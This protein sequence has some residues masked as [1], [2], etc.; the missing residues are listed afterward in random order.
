VADSTPEMEYRETLNKMEGIKK[1]VKL[2]E[3]GLKL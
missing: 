2:A 1:A 3:N